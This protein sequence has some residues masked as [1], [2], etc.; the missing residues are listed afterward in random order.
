MYLISKIT[1]KT[2]SS[3][4]NLAGITIEHNSNK[5][6]EINQEFKYNSKPAE[7]QEV[8]LKDIRRSSIFTPYFQ[9]CKESEMKRFLKFSQDL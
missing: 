5:N 2:N 8:Q 6:P 1:E 4:R 3:L 9:S 7:N